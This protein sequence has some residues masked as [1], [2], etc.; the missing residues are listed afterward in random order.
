MTNLA[1]AAGAA[2]TISRCVRRIDDTDGA[3]CRCNMARAFRP[4]VGGLIFIKCACSPPFIGA[5]SYKTN[6]INVLGRHV[7]RHKI[8][9]P[10]AQGQQ[11][12]HEDDKYVA[13][14]GVES[15]SPK[16]FHLQ[17]TAIRRWL[18]GQGLPPVS[19]VDRFL[20]WRSPCWWSAVSG[21]VCRKKGACKTP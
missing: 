3:G 12:D 16:K 9:R 19:G 5:V 8:T 11:G 15:L 1:H 20:Q 17:P 4:G 6:S 14:G 21:R 7:Y 18:A 13:H 10:A 2:M